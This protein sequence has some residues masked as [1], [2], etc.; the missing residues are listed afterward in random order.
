MRRMLQLPAPSPM[1]TVLRFA[2]LPPRTDS[3]LAVGTI[4][5]Y[6]IERARADPAFYKT[7]AFNWKRV[8]FEGGF[9]HDCETLEEAIDQ[10]DEV[11]ERAL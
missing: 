2:S 4:R 1:L 5:G 8:T 9:L 6:L 7:V 11:E 10:L 3:R